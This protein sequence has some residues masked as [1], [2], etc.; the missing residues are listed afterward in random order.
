MKDWQT[1][2]VEGHFT[3]DEPWV[4]YHERLAPAMARIVGAREEEV[5]L[6][7]SLT[8]NLHLMMV[9]F[10]RPRSHRYRLLIEKPA[11]P[12]DRYAVE[13][14]VRFHGLDP[15]DALIEIGPR[16]G[17]SV[18]RTEDVLEI[19]DSRG[20]SIA[21]VMLPGIQY[22]SG[23]RFDM[24]AITTAARARGCRVG[25]DLA[26]AIG[27]VPLALH[28][29]DADFAVW[30]S[31]KYLNG[32]PGAVAGCFVHERHGQ[33][34]DLPRFAGWWGHEKA[35]RFR[36]DPGF[37]PSPGAEGWQLSNAPILGMSAMKASLELFASVGMDALRKKSEKLTGYLEYTVDQLAAEFPGESI[38]VITPRDPLRRGCQISMNCAGRERELYDDLL[39]AGV[40]ADFREPC[41]IR[42]APV[43]FYNSFEDVHTFGRVMR[44]LLAQGPTK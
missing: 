33:D 27:N 42:M 1:L 30:C 10:Y 5:V 20:E 2:A 22:Y 34:P 26:H 9:S 40:I 19:L 18:I 6:M 37:R 23:Q 3:G 8:V 17:E 12:S 14:Q 29:W 25:W 21:L 15:A 38:S 4:P 32:G 13:S 7:N 28:D 11:F 44:E 16:N 31:Y 24:P 43:P 35:T 36:M 41:I 39:A